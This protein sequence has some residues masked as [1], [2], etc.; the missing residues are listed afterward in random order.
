MIYYCNAVTGEMIKYYRH[1]ITGQV[2]TIEQW[3]EYECEDW[4]DEENLE[5]VYKNCAGEWVSKE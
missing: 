5:E 2:K 4:F 1:S 3:S